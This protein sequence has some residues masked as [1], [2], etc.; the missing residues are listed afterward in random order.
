MLAGMHVDLLPRGAQDMIRAE[1]FPAREILLG[2]WNDLLVTPVP[3]LTRRR[4]DELAVLRSGRVPYQYLA[5][6]EP[7][8]AYAEWLTSMLPDVKITVLPGTGHF[9]QLARPA[10]VARLLTGADRM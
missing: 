7:A 3:E 4:A 5:G 1:P 6:E 9:P 10:E 8:P 2:Y